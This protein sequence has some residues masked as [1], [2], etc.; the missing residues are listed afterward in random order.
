[1]QIYASC[2]VCCL[3]NFCS[4]RVAVEYYLLLPLV[5]A[6]LNLISFSSSLGLEDF[7]ATTNR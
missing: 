2:C 6:A 5:R 3:Q 7:G 4:C 1:M